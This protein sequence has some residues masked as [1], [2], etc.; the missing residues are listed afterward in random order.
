M[1]GQHVTP[2]GPHGYCVLR[3]KVTTCASQVAA[4]LGTFSVQGMKYRQMPVRGKQLEQ[5]TLA[6]AT[7]PVQQSCVQASTAILHAGKQLVTFLT[8]PGYRRTT[9]PRDGMLPT[10]L[11]STSEH[12]LQGHPLASLHWLL[13]YQHDCYTPGGLSCTRASEL[14]TLGTDCQ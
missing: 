4:V 14:I 10:Q 11:V 6:A 9:P 8:K 3:G 12:A 7:R 1:C 2:D 5:P 13:Q